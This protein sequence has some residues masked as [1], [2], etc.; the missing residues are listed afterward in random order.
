MDTG[1]VI[2][3]DRG[4]HG[5]LIEQEAIKRYYKQRIPTADVIYEK[6][7]PGFAYIALITILELDELIGNSRLILMYLITQSKVV[8]QRDGRV[9]Y[10]ICQLTQK[11]D[12]AGIGVAQW[13]CPS[14]YKAVAGVRVYSDDAYRS[15]N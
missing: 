7:T 2:K 1:I 5:F 15:D 4:E 14:E 12:L 9:R 13:R 8:K 10:F 6:L 11:K 3:E